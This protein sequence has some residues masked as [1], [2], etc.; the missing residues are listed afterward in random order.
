VSAGAAAGK[1]QRASCQLDSD[2]EQLPQLSV[3]PALFEK[4]QKLIYSETGIWLGSSKTALL[5]GRLF[6]RLR[7]LQITSLESYY[8]CVIQPEQHEERA[9]MIDAITTNETRFFREPRQR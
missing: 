6:R 7:T 9:R 5:C 4:F 8:E 3:S 1:G 2:S